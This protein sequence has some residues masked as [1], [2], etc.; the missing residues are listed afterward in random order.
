MN[1]ANNIDWIERNDRL[2][3]TYVFKN[4]SDALLFMGQ[5]AKAI[6]ELNHHPEWTN[7]YNKV[8]VKLCTHDIGNKISSLDYQLVKIL[9]QNY[10]QFV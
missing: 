1:T 8:E 7:I 3:K 4:F 6:D 10:S 5:S 9:D 2:C